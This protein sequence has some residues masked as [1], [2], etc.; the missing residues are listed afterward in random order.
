MLNWSWGLGSGLGEEGAESASASPSASPPSGTS[1]KPRLRSRRLMEET[2]GALERLA[3]PFSISFSLQPNP[4]S[5]ML[6]CELDASPVPYLPGDEAGVL[7]LEQR[8]VLLH[9][10]DREPRPRPTHLWSH[11]L[12]SQ[13]QFISVERAVEGDTFPISKKDCFLGL[14]FRLSQLVN[15]ILHC[16]FRVRVWEGSIMSP[17]M[18]I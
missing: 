13:S 16:G 6:E 12:Y 18:N 10:L 1:S 7:L 14:S 15:S 11:L 3:S 8:D 2:E 5:T 17:L 4:Q 9:R